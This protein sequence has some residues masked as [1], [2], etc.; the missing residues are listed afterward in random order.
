MYI[1]DTHL[2]I[3]L[4]IL[5]CYFFSHLI[6]IINHEFMI[7]KKEFARGVANHHQQY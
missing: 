7:N 2:Y 6:I 3:I 5:S 4:F 1:L